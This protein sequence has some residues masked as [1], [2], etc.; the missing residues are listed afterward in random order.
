MTACVQIILDFEKSWAFLQLAQ[1]FVIEIGNLSCLSIE[2]EMLFCASQAG[3]Y[4][5]LGGLYCLEV[6]V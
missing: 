6:R 2:I 3:V 1:F 4:C 5:F